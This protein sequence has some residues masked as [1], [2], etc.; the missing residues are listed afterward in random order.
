L[1][2]GTEGG[3]LS[4]FKDGVIRTFGPQHGVGDDTVVQILEDDAGDLWLGT[5]RGIFRILRRDME[6]LLAGRLVRVH[7]RAF[8]QS[9]GLLSAQCTTGFGAALKTRDGR[10]FFSTDRALV[11]IEPKHVTDNP[12]PPVVRLENLLVGGRAWRIEPGI[13]VNTN[14]VSTT[15]LEIPPGQQRFEFQY[16]ALHFGAPERVRFRYRL[17][18]LDSDW[19]EAGTQRTAHFSYLPPGRYRFQVAAHN[20]D[21]QWR[22][23]GPT[24]SLIVLPHF[25][26][27]WWFVLGAWLGGAGVVSGGVAFVIRRRHK[28]RMEMLERR[29]SIESERARI[30]QDLHDDLGAGLTEIGLTSELVQDASLAP[31]EVR[32]YAGEISTRARELV[33][34]LDEIVWAVN[35]RND[36]APAVAA[37]FSQFAQRMLKPLGMGCRLDIQRNLA[38][39]PLKADQRHHLFLAFKEAVT[40]IA[41]HAHAKEVRLAIQVHGQALTIEVE[42]DGVG[43]DPG[44]SAAGAD[45]L[46]NMRERLRRLNGTC[47]ITSEPGRGTTLSFRLPLETAGPL[48]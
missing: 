24:V 16:T 26:Q 43:F 22:E 38:A 4:C 41:R 21:G 18:G 14:L 20:G 35:P 13:P 29:R 37:Y 27:T 40:N 9:D 10:L 15:T 17:L 1:W 39:L 32:G 48:P 5:Y 23:S 30:A 34:A 8:D 31:A 12:A 19:V 46:S 44:T 7:P 25:W 42:D 6:G 36:S 3:G 47:E 11:V 2:I 45:G 33:A 28:A